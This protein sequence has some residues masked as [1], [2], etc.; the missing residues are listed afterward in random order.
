MLCFQNARYDVSYLTAD[1]NN[2][3]TS[4]PKQTENLMSSCGQMTTSVKSEADCSSGLRR[5]AMT[6]VGEEMSND[7]HEPKKPA[8]GTCMCR[9]FVLINAFK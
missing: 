7:S 3:D 1:R 2:A 9:L 4:N 6:C 5:T 8:N